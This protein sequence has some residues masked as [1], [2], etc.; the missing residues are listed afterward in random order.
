[1]H[2]D[3]RYIIYELEP[4][5][6]R[7]A[8]IDLQHLK[9]D[10]KFTAESFSGSQGQA[11]ELAKDVPKREFLGL[12]AEFEFTTHFNFSFLPSTF[13]GRSSLSEDAE[14]G[15]RKMLSW[16]TEAT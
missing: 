10:L 11:D 12:D 4:R 2:T 16:P 6:E 1:M 7:R 13:F 5:Q 8:R 3:C 14:E 9:I 15:S